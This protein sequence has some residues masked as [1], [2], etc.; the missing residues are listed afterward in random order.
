MARRSNSKQFLGRSDPRD[1]IATRHI[2]NGGGVEDQA[3]SARIQRASEDEG[4]PATGADL[5]V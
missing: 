1:V 5:P 3:G 4:R 2:R